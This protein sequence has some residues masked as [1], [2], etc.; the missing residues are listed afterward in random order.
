MVVSP[1]E[2]P[3]FLPKLSELAVL[4][5]S[6]PDFTLIYQR[7]DKNTKANLLAKTAKTRNTIF[8]FIGISFLYWFHDTYNVFM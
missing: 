2:W 7:W 4:R 1:D 6:F 3:G 5:E 8:S